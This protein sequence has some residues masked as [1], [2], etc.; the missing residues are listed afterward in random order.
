MVISP[1]D[2]SLWSRLTGNKYPSTPK[3]R[4]QKGPEVQRF[5]QNLGREGMLEGKQQEEKK[6]ER[7]LPEKIATGALIAGGVA[8]LG[9]AARDKRVQD[10]AQR[11]G[12][13]VRDKTQAFLKNL[14]PGEKVDVEIIDN[15]GDVTPDPS[16]QQENT[17]PTQNQQDLREPTYNQ[18]DVDQILKDSRRIVNKETSIDVTPEKDTFKSSVE[19]KT[20][21]SS[22][23]VSRPEDIGDA[24]LRSRRAYEPMIDALEK[25]NPGINTSS[26]RRQMLL[27][28][29]K[30]VD[31]DIAYKE[32]IDQGLG[33]RDAVLRARV[34]AGFT[35]GGE[36]GKATPY[37]EFL[38]TVPLSTIRPGQITSENIADLSKTTPVSERINDLVNKV[39]G[40][41][42]VRVEGT[43]QSNLAELGTWNNNTQVSMGNQTP[44]NKVIKGGATIGGPTLVD[45][46]A[47]KMTVDNVLDDAK[48]K[49]SQNRVTK[50]ILPRSGPAAGESQQEFIDREFSQPPAQAGDPTPEISGTTIDPNR[51][52]GGTVKERLTDLKNSNFEALLSGNTTEGMQQ[53][54]GGRLKDGNTYK[55]NPRL[56]ARD[57]EIITSAQISGKT[58][59]GEKVYF[60]PE[61]TKISQNI[62][63]GAQFPEVLQDPTRETVIFQ[64]EEMDRTKFEKPVTTPGAQERYENKVQKQLDYRKEEIGDADRNFLN[65]VDA[66]EN[67]VGKI[68]EGQ[69]NIKN[70]VA[71]LPER[72]DLTSPQKQQTAKRLGE[73]LNLLEG[74]LD[75]ERDKF[76]Q[77]QSSFQNRTKGIIE[78]S[79]NI[80]D[81]IPQE[82]TTLSQKGE[83]YEIR[84]KFD[85]STGKTTQTIQPLFD[86]ARDSKQEFDTGVGLEKEEFDAS[87]RGSQLQDTGSR[88]KYDL[89][90]S[91]LKGR[92]P[93]AEQLRETLLASAEKQGVDLTD[94]SAMQTFMKNKQIVSNPIPTGER[95]I[96]T[97]T[98]VAGDIAEIYRTGDPATVSKRIDRFMVEKDPTG[99]LRQSGVE[100][101]KLAQEKFAAQRRAR[102]EVDYSAGEQGPKYL[103]TRQLEAFKRGLPKGYYD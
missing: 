11:A 50:T 64:G 60:G 82:K 4:A 5:I 68:Q 28:A 7:S 95:M 63:M 18:E 44:D 42:I 52:P 100:Q 19:G 38:Q 98:G 81:N 23:A 71:S 88:R 58:I 12:A 32:G 8:A 49:V 9:A 78:S 37:R 65:K 73:T 24:R 33:D 31:Y 67:M 87:S 103:A 77:A 92:G 13:T 36:P 43:D 54:L 69:Q 75:Q 22:G 97:P 74:R 79:Q 3:E 30:D 1:N 90:I 83:P 53:A 6:K 27:N 91:D 57:A 85:P 99:E 20:F 102:G 26:A 34:I 29:Q 72:R 84:E 89:T 45:E 10:V 51:F 70:I 48:T 101:Q 39:P 55:N 56:A 76:T 2:F 21:G 59:Q 15:T 62:R 94:P 25:K 17:A 80:I 66:I 46:Q 40:G 61:V 86:K 41:Q 35:G 47:T 96:G 93:G 16:V 14:G